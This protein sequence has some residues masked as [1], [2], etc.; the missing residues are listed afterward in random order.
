MEAKSEASCDTVQGRIFGAV[1]SELE[2]KSA[3]TELHNEESWRGEKMEAK[4][5]ASCDTV[6]GRIFGAVPS[7]SEAK[8]ALTELHNYTT[9]ISSPG[10]ILDRF[11]HMLL[12]YHPTVVQSDGYRKVRTALSFL[13][14]DSSFQRVVVSLSCDKVLWNAVMNNKEVVKMK[15]R[16]LPVH[17][18]NMSMPKSCA[19]EPDLALRILKWILELTKTKILELIESFKSLVNAV[20]QAHYGGDLSANALME[21]NI[22]SSIL[23]CIFNL[24]I[25]I[26]ARAQRIY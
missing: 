23:L 3:L 20:F 25:I 15:E 22:A 8:S 26:L 19:E 1:P 11:Q 13:H 14:S 6:Q 16:L 12:G 18:L 21:E 17:V 5:E 7:E 2:A 24:L 10:T 9:G 4:S